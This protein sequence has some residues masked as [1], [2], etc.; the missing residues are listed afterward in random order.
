M[1]NY[2]SEFILLDSTNIWRTM[3]HGKMVVVQTITENPDL[4]FPIM[5]IALILAVAILACW[6]TKLS[7]SYGELLLEETGKLLEKNKWKKRG[8][9]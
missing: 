1:N 6:M 9:K 7:T 8:Y 5:F 3:A 4:A 2:Y